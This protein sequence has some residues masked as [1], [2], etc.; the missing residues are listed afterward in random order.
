MIYFFFFAVLCSALLFAIDRCDF[1]SANLWF[2]SHDCFTRFFNA[3][4]VFSFLFLFL[5]FIIL[6]DFS[7][8]FSVFFLLLLSL[9]RWSNFQSTHTQHHTS[10]LHLLNLYI[11][12][13]IAGS[14]SANVFYN[15]RFYRGIVLDVCC[16]WFL[17]VFQ[18]IYMVL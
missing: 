2:L 4:F 8:Y 9:F 15:S 7:T 17:L 10:N 16:K 6:F 5:F 3:D 12:D 18:I 13:E 11:C 1:L 14:F